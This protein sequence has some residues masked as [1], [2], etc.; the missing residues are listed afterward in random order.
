MEVV[1]SE[2]MLHICYIIVYMVQP[3]DIVTENIGKQQK[4]R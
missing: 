4:R 1:F 2:N 3:L